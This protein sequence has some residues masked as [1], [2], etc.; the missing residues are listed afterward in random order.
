MAKNDV[1]KNFEN[2]LKRLEEIVENLE[3]NKEMGLEATVQL[4]KEGMEKSKECK[5]ALEEVEVTVNN[6]LKD[7]ATDS[8]AQRND[9][10]PF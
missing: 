10:V 1:I 2:N 8:A 5:K 4:F 6:V 7:S 9:D 3:T